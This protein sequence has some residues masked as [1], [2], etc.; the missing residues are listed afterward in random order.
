[1]VH[2]LSHE[3]P[4][5]T[6]ELLNIATQQTSGKEVVGAA[7]ILSNVEATANGGRA[8]PTKAT[9][10][11]TRKGA[12]GGKKGQKRQCHHIAI[13]ASNGV[14]NEEVGDSEEECVVAAQHYFKR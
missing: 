1:L 12:K 7:F 14:D 3:Q 5:T 2:E 9:A 6:K 4:K 8:V 11:G 13:V 10:M